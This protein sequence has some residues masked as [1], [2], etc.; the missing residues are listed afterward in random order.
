M[1]LYF[2]ELPWSFD[3]S[4]VYNIVDEIAAKQSIQDLAAKLW[5]IIP[6][7]QLANIYPFSKIQQEANRCGFSIINTIYRKQLNRG[8]SIIHTDS[9]VGEGNPVTVPF[10]L[11]IPLENS[12]GAVTR[13]YNFDNHPTLN[14]EAT[15]FSI[16][17]SKKF[18]S[19]TPSDATNFL[20]YCV[21]EYIMN[22]PVAINT[23]IPHN[24]DFRSLLGNR[25]I[26]SIWF[27]QSGTHNLATW[28]QAK[29]LKNITV[30]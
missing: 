17:D 3:F 2:N 13:W 16:L 19:F 21:A 24:V 23:A 7:D 11:N 20:K 26:L 10:S 14:S 12:S 9:Y 1:G 27:V 5:C 25:S 18:Q 4:S 30:D 8:F 29:F 6:Y 22:S 28:E 15:R